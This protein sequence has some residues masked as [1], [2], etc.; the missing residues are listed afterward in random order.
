MEP[1]F[2]RALR[3]LAKLFKEASLALRV[4]IRF[5]LIGGL[6]V[7]AWGAVRATQDID[8]LADSDPSPLNR[9]EFRE[10]LRRYLEEKGCVAEWRVGD[11]DDPIPLLLRLELP[12]P[13]RGMAVDILWAHKRW[14]RQALVR[15]IPLKVSR[16]EVFVLRPED[17]ILMKLEAGGP[18]DLLDVETLISNPPPELNLRSL[19]QRAATLRLGGMLGECLR[20]ARTKPPKP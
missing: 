6:G 20:S 15:S 7:S 16:L 4:P 19:E 12:R 14:Q 18:Q 10:R 11:P 3:A 2:A 5:A 17:L 9:G 13:V 1:R 8:L